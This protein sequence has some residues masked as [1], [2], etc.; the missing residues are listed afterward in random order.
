MKIRL[1]PIAV[2]LMLGLAGALPNTARARPRPRY[3][4]TVPKA[5]SR[6]PSLADRIASPRAKPAGSTAWCWPETSVPP[7]AL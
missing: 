3:R 4:S 6:S 2:P 1:Y 5:E 7:I